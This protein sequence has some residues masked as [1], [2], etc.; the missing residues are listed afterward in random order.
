MCACA[1]EAGIFQDNKDFTAI[2]IGAD[3][4]ET[5]L[6]E[7]KAKVEEHHAYIKQEQWVRVGG[8][9]VLFEEAA[10]TSTL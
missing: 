6:L 3:G 4:L 2:S 8:I 10:T 9:G 1:T 5:K 7:Y